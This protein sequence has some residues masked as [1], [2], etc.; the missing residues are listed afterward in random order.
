MPESPNPGSAAARERG[1]TCPVLDNCQGRFSPRPP[2]GWY[3]R[4]GCPVHATADDIVTEE[5]PHG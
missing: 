1:C 4:V 2:D 5:A 3:I